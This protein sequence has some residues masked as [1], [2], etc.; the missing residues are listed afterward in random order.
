MGHI[1]RKSHHCFFHPVPPNKNSNKRGREND[2]KPHTLHDCFYGKSRKS[3]D[4]RCESPMK[5]IGLFSMCP[6]LVSIYP[7]NNQPTK[8]LVSTL[9]PSKSVISWIPG[10][11][12][13][14]FY[15]SFITLLSS[16]P[17]SK[18]CLFYQLAWYT[19]FTNHLLSWMILQVWI[20]IMV[21][22]TISQKKKNWCFRLVEWV[23]YQSLILQVSG[24]FSTVIPLGHFFLNKSQK[25]KL[26]SLKRLFFWGTKNSLAK[27]G[28]VTSPTGGLLGSTV[29][30]EPPRPDAAPATR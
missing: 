13:P 22:E 23:I 10:Q 17:L 4:W 28:S 12:H 9:I 18:V 19:P 21:Y 7:L 2:T 15:F 8:H 30:G 29:P 20:L 27:L 3:H 6:W 26:N 16:R 14:R 1:Q 24:F 25:K 5:Q 11:P